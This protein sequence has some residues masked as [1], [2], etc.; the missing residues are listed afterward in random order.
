MLET[1]HIKSTNDHVLFTRENSFMNP[2]WHATS[3]KQKNKIL[4]RKF[5]VF[6]QLRNKIYLEHLS[7]TFQLRNNEQIKRRLEKNE[8]T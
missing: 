3:N 7:F 8:H 1:I 4:I 2:T 6:F 5:S